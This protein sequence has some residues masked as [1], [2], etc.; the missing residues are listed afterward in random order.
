MEKI[1]VQYLLTRPLILTFFLERVFGCWCL[2]WQEELALPHQKALVC[3]SGQVTSMP[4]KM[5]SVAGSCTH[6]RCRQ[7]R[8][9]PP[10]DAFSSSKSNWSETYHGRNHPVWYD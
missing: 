1:I 3:G 10:S 2:L 7:V 8:Y 9:A 5:Y 4:S 6:E